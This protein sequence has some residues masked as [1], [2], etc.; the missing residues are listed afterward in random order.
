MNTPDTEWVTEFDEQF[1]GALQLKNKPDGVT[2]T[3]LKHFIHQELQKAREEE[4]E[5]RKKLLLSVNIVDLVEKMKEDAKEYGQ[6][7]DDDCPQMSEWA[8]VDST[9]DC[10]IIKSMVQFAGE[11]MGEVNGWWAIHAEEHRKHCSPE[12]NKAIT[13]MLGKKNRK[14]KDQSELDQAIS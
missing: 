13:R 7:H 14:P 12:G 3:R 6:Y 5:E 10:Q 2:V 1:K 9:C 11:W 4:R 8:D